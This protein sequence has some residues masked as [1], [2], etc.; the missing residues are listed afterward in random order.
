M[1][2]ISHYTLLENLKLCPKIQFSKKK[3][4]NYQ[5]EFLIKKA[6]ILGNFYMPDLP[7]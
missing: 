3:N 7:E 4:Q 1:C 6:M 2:I 5:F